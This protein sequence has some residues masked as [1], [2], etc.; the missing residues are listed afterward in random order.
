MISCEFFSMRGEFLKMLKAIKMFTD[1]IEPIAQMNEETKQLKSHTNYKK[2]IN[3][4]GIGGIGK[5]RFLSEF[6]RLLRNEKSLEYALASLDAYEVD[7]PVKVLIH[8]RKQL[9]SYQFIKFDYALIQYFTKINTPPQHIISEFSSIKSQYF[10]VYKTIGNDILETFV[11]YYSSIKKVFNSGK[12]LVKLNEYKKYEADFSFYE[13]MDTMELFHELPNIFAEAINESSEPLVILLDDFDSYL[14]KVQSR[15]NSVNAESWLFKIYRKINRVLFVIASRDKIQSFGDYEPQ[16]DEFISNHLSNLSDQDVG[17]YLDYANITHTKIVETIIDASKGVPLYLD[18]FVDYYYENEMLLKDCKQFDIP[19]LEGLITRYLSHLSESEKQV[20][21]LIASF[22]RID[23]NFIKYMIR[24]RNIQ[25]SDDSLKSFLDRTLFI[26]DDLYLK[27]DLTLKDH[28]LNSKQAIDP[29]TS[30]SLLMTY[31]VEEINATHLSYEHYLNQLISLYSKIDEI[32]QVEIENWIRIINEIGDRSY[33]FPF[34]QHFISTFNQE[35]P[36]KKAIYIYYDLMKTRRKGFVKEGRDKMQELILNH[37]DPKVYGSM[38][39]AYQLLHVFFIHLSGDYPKAL[40]GYKEIIEEHEL[41]N[42]LD[43]DHRTLVNA[44]YKYGDLLFLYGKFNESKKVLF[45]I[46]IDHRVSE[47]NKCEIIRTRAHI[48]RL[49]YHFEFA[50]RMY[51]KILES[52]DQTDY[53]I[54]ANTTTSMAENLQFYN[55]EMAIKY[56]I[57]AIEKNEKIGSTME[58]GKAYAA[59]SIAHTMLGE[60]EEA[61]DSY[62]NAYEIQIKNGYRSGV[63]FA[64]IAK[65]LLKYYSENSI[66]I[67]LDDCIRDINELWNELGVYYS[68][69]IIIEILMDIKLDVTKDIDWL[70]YEKTISNL[71]T[72]FNNKRQLY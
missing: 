38:M 44:L 41:F 2:M 34:D 39:Y 62:Q 48:Y 15:S 52:N 6:V 58:I 18:L 50:D 5:T 43:R 17:S 16:D 68:F 36:A 54:I 13:D 70:D 49:N 71:K 46:E 69:G 63:L 11:P 3:Y 45:G 53:R 14:K 26:D 32:N 12:K 67:S 37:F 9:K 7:S 56:A 4:Y 65:F 60:Y 19:K 20:V 23:E 47:A 30:A 31:L 42:S 28:I 1:R 35:N 29:K 27:L 66:K 21:L 57:D 64:E 51:K 25:I 59:K 10:D 22:N 8:I 55:P 61:F 33:F 72:I 24:N 40:S